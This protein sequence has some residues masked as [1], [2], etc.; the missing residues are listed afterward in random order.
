M[1]YVGGTDLHALLRA[2]GALSTRSGAPT[3]SRRSPSALDAAHAPASCTAT[4]SR[5]TWLLA[6]DHAYL[7][8]FGLTRLAGSDTG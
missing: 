6:G 8:D 7:S 5:P 3:S 1:R 2:S 4:S